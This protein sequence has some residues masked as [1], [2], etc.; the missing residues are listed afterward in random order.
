CSARRCST[1]SGP[2][3]PPPVA[4]RPPPPDGRE[5]RI[6][7]AAYTSA[8]RAQRGSAAPGAP[9]K[10]RLRG[11]GWSEGGPGGASGSEPAPVR[12][13]RRVED[14][15]EHPV[16]EPLVEGIG[17]GVARPGGEQ[18]LDGAAGARPGRRGRHQTTADPTSA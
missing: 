8:G 7:S 15:R 14:A 4:A 2:A 5:E 6:Q 9:A 17:G 18:H 1:S 10:V 12:L 11:V 13:K 16:A 3:A